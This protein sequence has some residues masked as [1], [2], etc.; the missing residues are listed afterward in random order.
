V[1]GASPSLKTSPRT[2]RRWSRPSSWWPITPAPPLP[3]AGFAIEHAPQRLA[4]QA[5]TET[6]GR[7]RRRHREAL[8]ATR[9]LTEAHRE[10]FRNGCWALALALRGGH[11][12]RR[13]WLDRRWQR[14]RLGHNDQ[15]EPSPITPALLPPAHLA[16]RAGPPG[17]AGLPAS[18]ASRCG[19]AAVR[20]VTALGMAGAIGTLAALEQAPPATQGRCRGGRVLSPCA[21]NGILRRTQGS[22]RSRRSSLGGEWL[23]PPRRFHLDTTTLQSSAGWKDTPEVNCSR[24]KG[25]GS[26]WAGQTRG[27]RSGRDRPTSAWPVAGR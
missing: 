23:L 24:A 12:S 6:L 18:P 26:A 7:P 17:A 19:A 14:R 2:S 27:R 8:V 25:R 10:I 13:S 5:A 1:R 9:P 22:W 4:A 21:A 16:G 11:R 20:A 3:R 15:G